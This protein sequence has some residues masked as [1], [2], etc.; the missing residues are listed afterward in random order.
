[1]EMETFSKSHLVKALVRHFAMTQER[2][3]D[4]VNCV[5]EE[6]RGAVGRGE[7]VNL[8]GFGSFTP[9]ETVERPGRNPRTG[10]LIMVP[11]GRRVRFKPSVNILAQS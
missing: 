10:E 7:R 2:A 6:M 3:G 4:V 9:I 8:K 5:V 11:A 1:M